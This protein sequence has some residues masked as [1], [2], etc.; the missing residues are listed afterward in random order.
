MFMIILCE[1]LQLQLPD[2]NASKFDYY[3]AV[4]FRF[5]ESRICD[6]HTFTAFMSKFIL[7]A[8]QTFTVDRLFFSQRAIV[9]H[10]ALMQTTSK[11]FFFLNFDATKMLL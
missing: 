5:M 1:P 11:H 9:K 3:F 10:C 8:V 2:E 6:F 7:N 4:F